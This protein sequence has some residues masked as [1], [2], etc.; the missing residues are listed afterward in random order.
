MGAEIRPLDVTLHEA[1]H[2]VVGVA[3]GLRLKEAVILPPTE[4]W[5]GYAW[6]ER[7]FG[8]RGAIMSAAGCFWERSVGGRGT[9]DDRAL[10]RRLG[11]TS[12]KDLDALVISAGAILTARKRA[13]KLV[14]KAL[15]R[16]DLSGADITAIAEGELPDGLDV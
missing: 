15:L 9:S 6:F 1:A 10:I 5:G 3:L 7:V 13:H 11:F 14:T 8:V 4:D 16:H 2:V 12:R